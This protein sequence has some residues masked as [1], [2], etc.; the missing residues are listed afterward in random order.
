MASA[1]VELRRAAARSP[2]NVRARHEPEEQDLSRRLGVSTV[3]AALLRNRGLRTAEEALAWMQPRLT[4]LEE[5]GK[6]LDVAKAAKRL[7]HAVRERERILVYGDYD[8]DGM[9]GT[10][11]L[12]NFLRLAGADVAWHIP[13]RTKEGYSFN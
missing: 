4:A 10:V 8:V 7:A 2:W 1:D 11:I 6:I 9:T 3:M 13:N 5:P 12:V